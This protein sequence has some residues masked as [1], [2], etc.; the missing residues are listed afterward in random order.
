MR[1]KWEME[2]V[3]N[4]ETAL[5]VM[6][7][8]PY[9]V[10]ISD[11]RMPGMSGAELMKEVMR[12]YPQ[13]IRFILSGY[14]GK[15]LILQCAGT[16]HQYFS[17][18]CD[19][20]ILKSA[21]VQAIKLNQAIH[22]SPLQEL[23]N[24]I[25]Q[26]PSLFRIYVELNDLLKRSDASPASI[27]KVIERD[28]S[29]TAGI[30][31]LVNSAFFGLGHSI[32]TPGEAATYL[33]KETIKSLVLSLFVFSEFNTPMVAGFSMES[34][35]G[36]SLKVAMIAK[37]IAG[38]VLD[39]TKLVEESFTAGMLHDV[40]RLILLSKLTEQ[41]AKVI[42]RARENSTNLLVAEQLEF[43]VTHA[44]VG[45]Y[46]LGLWGL[47][48][49]I[50]EAVNWHHSP[51]KSF[52]REFNPTTAVHVADAL[53]HELEASNNEIL[54]GTLDLSYLESIGLLDR[55][56]EWR[57]LAKESVATGELS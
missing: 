11:M 35:W 22:D 28:I 33:G 12:L 41:Y 32:D 53:L 55:L 2:F 31:K 21:L 16:T 52:Y 18:P 57:H 14:A 19:I 40:G 13:T 23:I 8:T 47:P 49:P 9:D 17:K 27:G 25:A 39:D 46:L 15:E 44:G 54:K 5:A 50:V 56:D 42:E 45:G 20:E 3:M 30:L 24:Q 51:G 36:H 10:I 7:Q 29:M 26:L 48:G 6:A 43:S 38:T 34:L 1:D 4:G 37:K